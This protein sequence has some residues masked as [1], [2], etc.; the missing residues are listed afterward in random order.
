MGS[1]GHPVVALWV[2]LAVVVALTGCGRRDAGSRRVAYQA[3]AR[4]QS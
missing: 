3:T 4:P 1:R 2:A